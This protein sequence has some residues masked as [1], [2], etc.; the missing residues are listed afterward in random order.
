MSRLE[1]YPPNRT[2][3]TPL[4]GNEISRFIHEARLGSSEALGRLME[5]CRKYLL[6]MAGQELDSDLRPKGGASDLVQD[7]FL[8]AQRDFAHFRGTTE[9]EL[10]AWLKQILAHRLANNV[11]RYRGTRKRDIDREELLDSDLNPAQIVGG[12]PG[13]NPKDVAVGR[14]EECRLH[15]ALAR[16]PKHFQQVLALRTWQRLSFAEIGNEMNKSADSVRKLWGRAVDRLNRELR[17]IP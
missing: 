6:L 7:T 11:R 9:Q 1:P 15:M 4:I 10:L 17:K 3:N 2:T 5:G 16:L 8:E 13:A 12:D 14:E